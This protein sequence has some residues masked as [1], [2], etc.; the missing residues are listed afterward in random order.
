[1]GARNLPHAPRAANW[2]LPDR[3]DIA[4]LVQAE[5]G[6]LVGGLARSL[7]AG[8]P[9]PRG[10]PGFGLEHASGTA[11]ELLGRLSA[12][13]IFRKYERV[14]DLGSDLGATGRWLATR[15]G[16]TVVST[17][18]D[19]A[20]AAAGH[21]LTRRAQL[22]RQ[23]FHVPANPSHL[24]ALDARFTH[25]WITE[26]LPRLPDDAL[27]DAFRA[28]RPGGHLAVQD[29]VRRGDTTPAVPGWRFATLEARAARLRDAGFVEVSAHDVTRDAVERSA[30]VLAAREQLLRRLRA[31][32]DPALVAEAH[33][34]E[35]LAAALA[36]GRL[37]VA[38][39]VA[40]RP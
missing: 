28:L 13:G 36:D 11:R 17:A 33:A 39:L 30:P 7:A 10:L 12:H 35:A 15:L 20:E 9:P 34:R 31:G 16:C 3:D 6:A 14:L 32:G 27:D 29:V 26:A 38:Q 18:G 2:T 23:V 37:G 5:V 40:R 22:Q 24:P 8:S 4:P 25:V 1:M 21:A 19:V